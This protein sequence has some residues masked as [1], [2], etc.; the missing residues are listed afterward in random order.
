[1]ILALLLPIEP[2]LYL[3]NGACECNDIGI[4]GVYEAERRKSQAVEN[5]KKIKLLLEQNNWEPLRAE[6]RV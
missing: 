4:R 6:G 1:M 3:N 5:T 2:N